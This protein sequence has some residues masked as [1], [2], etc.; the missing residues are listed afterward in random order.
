MQLFPPK[1]NSE[2]VEEDINQ[3]LSV[4][5]RPRKKTVIPEKPRKKKE[6]NK[7]WGRGERYLVGGVLLFT[8]LLSSILGLLARDWKL[9]GMPRLNSIKLPKISLEKT[10]VIEGTQP[11]KDFSKVIS[12]FKSATNNLSGVYGLYV[13]ELDS[14][15]SFGV[16]EKEEFQ[17][18]SLIKLPV[19]IALYQE[20]QKGNLNLEEKYTLREE[21]RIT[22]SGSL[23]SKPAGTALTYRDLARLMGKQS[24]NTA[25]GIVR[26]KLGDVLIQNT[27]TEIGMTKTNLEEN[28]TSPS[29]IGLLLTKLYQG[30]LVSEKHKS[31]I[32]GYLTDTVYEQWLT[33]GV[34]KEVKVAH[35]YGRE[36]HVV[37]DAGVV[38][39]T[40]PYVVVIMTKG[41]VEREADEIF[42]TLSK[43]IYDAMSRSE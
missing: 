15:Q 8:I 3:N 13:M 14:G 24:D 32:L 17:A 30:K 35:K 38:M 21:D 10:F 19:L 42:P 20:A 6:V 7:P 22:G 25:F 37:N 43:I 39:M 27:I 34:P 28:L 16:D 1:N 2:E 36:I 9:P 26:K 4:S 5:E 11:K 29:D 18:A 41:V 31:E 12:D 40:K 33:A 23:S